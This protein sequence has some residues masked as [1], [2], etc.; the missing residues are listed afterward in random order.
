MFWS[1]KFRTW[2]AIGS[3]SS[4]CLRPIPP[5][6]STPV[7]TGH[8]GQTVERHADRRGG[9][10]AAATTDHPLIG[11]QVSADTD[12]LDVFRDFMAVPEVLEQKWAALRDDMKKG[13]IADP[14]LAVTELQMFAHVGRSSS[15]ERPGATDA[16]DA[17]EPV[18]AGGSPV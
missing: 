13:G 18:H 11:G 16:R 1:L 6:R 7:R 9:R 15:A 5:S 10:P 3:S 2:T 8:V 12:P 14:R 17:R 4:R